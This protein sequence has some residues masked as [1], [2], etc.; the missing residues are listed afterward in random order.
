RFGKSGIRFEETSA[1]PS[2]ADYDNDGILDLYFTSTYK[3][4]KSFL[5]KGNG[6]GTF[7]DVTWLADV[8]V[9][10][11]W[12]NAFADYDNDG[13]LDLIVAGGNGVRL[14]RN[15]GNN[16]H[17][18]HVRVV[19]KESNRAG[20][21]ARVT[22]TPGNIYPPPLWGR[23]RR[24]R[25]GGIQIREVQGGKGSGSQH[26]LPVEFGL[27]NYSSPLDVEVRFPSGKIIN[28]NMVTPDQMIVVE[29]D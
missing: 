15:D 7:T 14:F 12:G 9:D 2:F 10:D 17:W 1:D 18:L 16:N 4:K 23:G 21:G 20:I 11:G 8:R 6:D 25:E 5:Y 22:I 27:G 28:L 13:D 26:S 29:E 19:G 3:E 24:G